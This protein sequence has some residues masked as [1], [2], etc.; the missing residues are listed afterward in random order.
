MGPKAWTVSQAKTNTTSQRKPRL[1]GISGAQSSYN[2]IKKH[3]PAGPCTLFKRADPSGINHVNSAPPRCQ[4]IR[5]MVALPSR[6]RGLPVKQKWTD[7]YLFVQNR[8][9]RPS[10]Y[11]CSRPAQMTRR[12]RPAQMTRRLDRNTDVSCRAEGG[13]FPAIEGFCHIT[14][15]VECLSKI[16]EA[17][18][19]Q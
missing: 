1:C 9:R 2:K 15:F 3:P 11:R 16:K 12:R 14:H 13:F 5:L 19:P 4:S 18:A 8:R 6:F 17:L 7:M 10:I